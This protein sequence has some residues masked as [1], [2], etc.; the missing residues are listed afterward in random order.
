MNEELRKALDDLKWWRDT[1][2][3]KGVVYI[4]LNN[5]NRDVKRIEEFIKN[6]IMQYEDE[7]CKLRKEIAD[8]ERHR[9]ESQ[10]VLQAI[11]K[12]HI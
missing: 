8:L 6:R 3:E 11:Q 2:E 1:N 12:A 5:I 10:Q 9:Y 7:N 4:P